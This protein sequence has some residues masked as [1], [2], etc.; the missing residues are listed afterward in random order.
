MKKIGGYA[1]RYRLWEFTVV[2][3]PEHLSRVQ[4]YRP[5]SKHQLEAF[6]QGFPPKAS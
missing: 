4:R 2:L 5:I 3:A 1:S 6:I